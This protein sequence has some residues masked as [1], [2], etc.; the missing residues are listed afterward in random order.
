[1]PVSLPIHSET[2]AL[3]TT[4]TKQD[5]G[6]ALQPADAAQVQRATPAEDHPVNEPVTAPALNLS[7]PPAPMVN[8]ET[9]MSDKELLQ[10]ERP[11]AQQIDQGRRPSEVARRKLERRR[12]VV[13]ERRAALEDDFQHHAISNATYKKGVAKYQAE[14]AKYRKEINAG[15]PAQD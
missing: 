11:E 15:A 14:I 12:R 5:E 2:K 1:M 10:G 8:P 13:E 9:A 7:A 3:A 6:S 4:E